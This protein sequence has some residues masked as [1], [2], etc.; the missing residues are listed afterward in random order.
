MASRENAEELESA[1]DQGARWEGGCPCG[2]VRYVYEGRPVLS[3]KCHCL[4][5]QAWSGAGHV[6]MLWAWRDGFRLT[7][8]EPQYHGTSGGSGKLV[9]RG[10]CPSCGGAISLEIELIP[11]VVGLVA[12]S[13]D[14]PERFRPEFELW[15]SRTSRA[16]PW[17]PP[18]P[19]L[20]Q[21][22]AGFARDVILDR[23]KR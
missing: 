14:A 5:C 7:A 2:N 11:K 17:D 21:F 16:T 19:S 10:R 9:Q 6:A 12:A 1:A 20:R 8:G 15:T 22:E 18:D 4:D 13:L 23:L 3:L